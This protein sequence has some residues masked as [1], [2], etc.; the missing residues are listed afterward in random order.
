MHV[1]NIASD[2]F[3]RN[4]FPRRILLAAACIL[5]GSLTQ[6]RRK[7]FAPALPE[8]LKTAVNY[9]ALDLLQSITVYAGEEQPCLSCSYLGDS[10][11]K[12][13]SRHQLTS[14]TG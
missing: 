10:C 8:S 14:G 13:T 6:S 3:Y 9:C 4:R 5:T 11:M 7:H 1:K 2:Q 12:F